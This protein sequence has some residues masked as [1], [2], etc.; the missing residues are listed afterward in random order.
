MTP[1]SCSNFDK[2]E[3]SRRNHIPNI[4]L[5]YKA[6]IIKTAWYWHKNRQI[7]HWN[8]IESPEI[9]SC[10]YG[11]LILTKGVKAQNGVKIA[12]STNGVG[13]SGQ[14]H[15]KKWNPTT[16][17]HHKTQIN[18][19]WLKEL[20]I[21]HNTIKV[22]EENISRKISDIPRSNI[23]TNMSLWTRDLEERINK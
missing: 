17:L 9:N 4:Q 5:Y 6:I 14:P 15:A 7:D 8:R 16:N 20:C 22:L 23:F 12:F 1:N 19:R 13:R 21:C 2:E 11:Q 3:W 10:L 18:S